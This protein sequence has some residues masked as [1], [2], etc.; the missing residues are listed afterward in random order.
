MDDQTKFM[1]E[2]QAFVLGVLGC[3]SDDAV[4]EYAC[5]ECGARWGHVPCRCSPVTDVCP[6][7]DEIVDHVRVPPITAYGVGK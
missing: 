5:G 4:A 7:C 2:C 1:R 3:N 6:K